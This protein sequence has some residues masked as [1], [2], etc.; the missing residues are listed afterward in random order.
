MKKPKRV[1]V[2]ISVRLASW[3]AVTNCNIAVFSH[4]MN[5]INIKLCRIV[6]L[7][8][9]FTSLLW[10][11]QIHT[12]CGGLDLISR[13]QMCQSHK[14]QIVSLKIFYLMYFLM[15]YS[16]V[17]IMHSVHTKYLTVSCVNMTALVV[18]Q[19]KELSLFGPPPPCH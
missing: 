9:F 8:G 12:K 13:S 3:L 7:I 15:L 19:K 11:Q 6:I 16:C 2:M 10:G 4:I 1:Q 17:K 18:D 14:L 5:M